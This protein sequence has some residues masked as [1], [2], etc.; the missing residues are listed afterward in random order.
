MK[1]DATHGGRNGERDRNVIVERSIV[2]ALAEVAVEMR[3][4]FAQASEALHNV[5]THRANEHPVHVEQPSH[6]GVEEKIDRFS[7][8]NR[9][10][11]RELD[12]VDA[13][14]FVVRAGSH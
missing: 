7:F 14:E 5:R 4:H 9:F 12:R 11:S 6:A 10:F 3:V 1:A 8:D 2:I 13:V